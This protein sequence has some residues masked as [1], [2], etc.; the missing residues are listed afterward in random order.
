MK[1]EAPEKYSFFKGLLG[2]RFAQLA[3]CGDLLKDPFKLW[4]EPQL[5]SLFLGGGCVPTLGV[6]KV[7][8]MSD[9]Q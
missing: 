8:H 1:G 6:A 9:L 4:G 7:E 2:F 5:L 3:L